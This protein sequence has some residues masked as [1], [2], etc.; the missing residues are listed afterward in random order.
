MACGQEAV[1]VAD[2]L[3]ADVSDTIQIDKVFIIGYKKTKEH[4]ISRELSVHDGQ[5]LTRAALA[6]MLQADKRK[7]INTSLFLEVD[8]STVDLSEDRV[9][10][11]IRVS[12]RWYFFQSPSSTWPIGILPNG[13]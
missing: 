11:I 5:V 6:E 7:L 3:Y 2:S 4:I 8:I 9:D 13:G 12:E 10:V 1:S